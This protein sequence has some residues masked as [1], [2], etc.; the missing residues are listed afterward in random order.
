[1]EK[2][3]GL[4]GPAPRLS[5]A[6]I[7]FVLAAAGLPGM[8]NFAGEILVL[9]GSAKTNVLFTVLAAGGIVLS[10]VYGLRMV[11]MVYLGPRRGAL[12]LRDLTFREALI[13]AVLGIAVLWL[14]IHPGPVVEKAKASLEAVQSPRAGGG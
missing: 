4:L 11:Q 12:D 6:G 9:V 2:M 1:M 3:G 7:F 14:G 13:L 10:I 5:G 8:G